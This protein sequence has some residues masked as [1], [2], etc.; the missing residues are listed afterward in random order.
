MNCNFCGSTNLIEGAISA[1]ASV[2]G[3]TFMPTD[4]SYFKKMFNA[5]G[6]EV[7]SYGCVHCGNLQFIVDFSEDDKKQYLEFEA[8]QPSVTERLDEND[9]LGEKL[10]TKE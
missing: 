4:E 5:G 7:H 6:R 9:V 1:G 8:Q 2:A 10:E 3:N